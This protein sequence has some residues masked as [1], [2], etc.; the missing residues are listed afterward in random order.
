[1]AR[2][3]HTRKEFYFPFKDALSTF[4]QRVKILVIERAFK[5]HNLKEVLGVASVIL[6]RESV[7][8]G[9]YSQSADFI[10]NN[11]YWFRLKLQN[12]GY[13]IVLSIEVVERLDLRVG[14][15]SVL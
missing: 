8:I 1:M 3:N 12:L 13:L 6:L 14:S 7:R 9:K 11:D 4:T 5:H 10:C 15:E 2:L